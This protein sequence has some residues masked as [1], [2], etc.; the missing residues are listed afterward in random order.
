MKEIK[1]K[2]VDMIL[3]DLPYGTTKCKWDVIIPL[4][5]LW[6]Q[7]NRIIKDDGTIVLFGTE[8]FSSLLRITNMEN[9]KYDWIWDKVKPNGHLVAKY[10][11]MQQ[12]ENISVFGKGK[13][14]YFPVM[15]PREKPKKSKEYT[16]TEIMGG[17]KTDNVG[18]ILKDKYPK[19]LITFSNASQ[20]NK[21]HPTQK[22]TSLLEYL[23]ITY[24]NENEIVLDNTM[25]SGSTGVACVNINRDFIG[26][27]LD[28]KY[29]NIAKNRIQE[30]ICLKNGIP[31]I[32]PAESDT[33]LNESA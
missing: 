21:V 20:K 11:P 9:Y 13:I 26:F 14:K 28:E 29:F 18:K 3:C 19:N 7:Y 4:E 25:G 30:A 10:R 6:E 32:K 15:T 23:I 2:S 12:T 8:P 5:A 27:E 22:L 16:R 31:M 33:S 24:T 1:D 17:K